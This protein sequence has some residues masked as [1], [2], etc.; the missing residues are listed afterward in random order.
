MGVTFGRD[1]YRN[2]SAEKLWFFNSEGRLEGTEVLK[3][4]S[5]NRIRAF[6]MTRLQSPLEEC[7]RE[8]AGVGLS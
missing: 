7:A 4:A 5:L 3:Y 2:I 6:I 8:G 1:A